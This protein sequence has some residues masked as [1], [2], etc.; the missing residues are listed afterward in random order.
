MAFNDSNGNDGILVIVDVQKE[1]E[2]YQP[3]GL[4][5]NLN[6]YCQKF[7][8]N[9]IRGVYQIWDSNKTTG[10]SWKFI[11][12][13][14]TIEKNYGTKFDKDLSRLT[15]HLDAKYPNAKEGDLFKIK[16][17]DEYIVRVVNNHN[18]FFVNN[19]LYHFFKKLKGM[20]VILTGGAKFECL[21]DVH[22]AM[23]TFGITPIYNDNYIYSAQTNDQQVNVPKPQLQQ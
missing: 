5:S 19:D 12:E 13:I 15:K 8:I 7:P 6:K 1:F 22:V 10:P 4:V 18:W 3:Q 9:G 23:K 17:E 2:Q 20:K 16:G 21:H 11:N 14:E